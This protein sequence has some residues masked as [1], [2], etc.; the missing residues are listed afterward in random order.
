MQSYLSILMTMMMVQSYLVFGRYIYFSGLYEPLNK[1]RFCRDTII[2]DEKVASKNLCRLF[3]I[4]VI[5]KLK[6]QFQSY[7]HS[8][9]KSTSSVKNE[10]FFNS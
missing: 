6:L 3:I 2:I 10:I 4:K 5:N 9:E 1:T 7:L 8:I